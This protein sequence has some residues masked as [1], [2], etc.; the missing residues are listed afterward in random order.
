MN[1]DVGSLAAPRGPYSLSER[2]DVCRGVFAMLVVVAH[3]FEL[4]ITLDPTWADGMPWLVRQA[5]A[6][7]PGVGTYYV[8]GFFI[9]SGYCIQGSVGRSS[10]GRR[11]SLGRYMAARA[12]RI[13][14]LYYIALA[15]AAAVEWSI[16]TALR[17]HFW[18]NNLDADAVG[19][20]LLMVQNLT[21]NF[22]S[23]SS[24]WSLTN[25]AAYYLLF[26]VL[27]A[28]CVP[29]G[30]KPAAAGMAACAGLGLLL[31]ATYRMGF[32]DPI[33]LKI[34]LL[35]GLGAVWHLGALVEIHGAALLRQSPTLARAARFW[36]AALAATMA[37]YASQRIHQEFIY[38]GAGATFALM[39]LRFVDLE[40]RR[41]GA[42]GVDPSPRRLPRLLGLSSYPVYLF[43][44]PILI[45]LGT[46]VRALGW[47]P[48]WWVAWL[49]AATTTVALCF[50]LGTLLEAPLLA[51]RAG[52]LRRLKPARPAPT[53]AAAQGPAL[54]A[55]P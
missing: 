16:P 11:F 54:G 47:S 18:Y 23:F 48:A 34:G 6:Y 5:V 4:A 21:K 41:G 30:R 53:P 26:G 45:L 17:P 13:L 49:A 22:G 50:P 3:S 28:M 15:F 31:Q 46:G 37:T 35:A 44:G 24:S 14:P 25:E 12:T 52:V 51:W 42:G 2:I 55:T 40:L 38:L 29:A 8:M 20:Q 9:L 33:I 43:H 10:S 36:P 39:M 1:D 32:R 27:A 19:Y 7:G